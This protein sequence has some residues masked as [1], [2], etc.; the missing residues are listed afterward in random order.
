MFGTYI[1]QQEYVW[2]TYGSTNVLG[3]LSYTYPEHMQDGPVGVEVL[4]RVFTHV[5]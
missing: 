4:T 2:N 1:V 5:F 3:L